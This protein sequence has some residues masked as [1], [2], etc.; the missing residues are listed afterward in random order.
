MK[1]AWDCYLEQQLT[2]PI[3]RCAFEMEMKDLGFTSPLDCRSR[4]SKNRN[5]CRC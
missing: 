1:T 5:Q 4:D 2:D 3:V